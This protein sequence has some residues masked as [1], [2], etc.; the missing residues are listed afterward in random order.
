M[1]ALTFRGIEE[2]VCERVEAPRLETSG[3]VIVEVEIAGL[4]GS[5]LHPYLGRERGLD[6]GTVMGHEFVGRVVEKGSDVRRLE[7]GDRVV[8]PF[9]TSCGECISC[10]SGL[11]ARC[12]AGQLFGWVEGGRGLH[13]A[14]AELVRVPLAESTLLEVPEDIASETALLCGDVLATGVFSADLAGVRDGSSVV[15]LGCG[16]VGL[17]SIVAA[18]ARGAGEVLA[19]DAV[20]ERLRFA[21]RFGATPVELAGGNVVNSVF[22]ATAGLGA[23]AVVEAVGSPEAMRLAFDLV[24]VGGTIAAPG[25]HTEEQFSF[26]PGEA[27]DKN[28]TYRAGRCPARVY[29]EE[30]MALVRAEGPVLSS[31]ITHRLSLSEGPDAYRIFARRMKGCVKVLLLPGATGAGNSL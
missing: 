26:S 4:C 17:M 6:P 19:V 31:I 14:Q 24:R 1:K 21:E 15:V 20:P 9:S 27:Y 12:Q 7:I 10:R 3:D 23:D 5:D 28:L 25:V 16:P 2:V 30:A 11:T 18:R 8:A 29:M 13:G 22:Q